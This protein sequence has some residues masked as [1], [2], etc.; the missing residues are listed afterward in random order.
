ME[1]WLITTGTSTDPIIVSPRRGRVVRIAR[2][3]RDDVRVD[4]VQIPV[5][6]RHQLL[7]RR[8]QASVL[9]ALKG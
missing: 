7:A 4:G 3:Q 9:V 1:G 6:Q 5:Q 2:E 8:F